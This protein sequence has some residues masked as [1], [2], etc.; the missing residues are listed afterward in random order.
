MFVD[1]LYETLFKNN[2]RYF[3]KKKERKKEKRKK[4]E[5]DKKSDSIDGK[6]YNN[7]IA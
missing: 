4:K 2:S 6:Y 5:K 1:R 7:S 3:R